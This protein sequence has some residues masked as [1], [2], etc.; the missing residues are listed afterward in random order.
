METGFPESSPATFG[1]VKVFVSERKGKAIIRYPKM[2]PKKIDQISF[3]RSFND[4]RKVVIIGSGAAGFACAETLRGYG[5]E[6]L[7]SIELG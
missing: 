5:Y 1:L 6:V 3:P 2:L 7:I 4:T